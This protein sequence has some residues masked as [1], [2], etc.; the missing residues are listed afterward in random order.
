MLICA[1]CAVEYAEPVPEVCPICAD[2]RQ[3]VPLDGQHWTSLDELA[4]NGEELTV[5]DLEPGMLGIRSR[6]SVGIGQQCI[7]VTTSQ[8]S[9]VWDPTGYVDDATAQRV[10]DL[11]PV[12]AIAAS[13]PHMFGVQVEW[14]RRLGNA[15]VLVAEAD[16]GWLGR[17]D[18]AIQTWSGTREIA[19]GLILHQVGGHFAGSACVLWKD[20]A[21]GDGVLLT[22]DTIFPNPD[23]RSV[24][25][26]RS[27]PNKIPLSGAVVQRIAGRLEALSFDRIY[28]NFNNVIDHDGRQVV[29]ASADRHTAWVRGDHDDLT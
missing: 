19:G 6:P 4:S 15:P 17:D 11:G 8:G 29:R 12:L 24:G 20:G 7:V 10:R 9:L 22:G 23:H 1:T 16:H 3:Y 5:H 27:Y 13:H 14:S 28:G 25:F 2:E 18:E 26:L 21:D